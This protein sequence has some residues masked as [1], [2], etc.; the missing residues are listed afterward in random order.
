VSNSNSWSAPRWTHSLARLVRSW[1]QVDRI[2]VSPS[3]GCWLRLKCG[4]LMR[5]DEEWFEVTSRS[6]SAGPDSSW[7]AYECAGRGQVAWLRAQPLASGQPRALYWHSGGE[8]RLLD[9]AEI[10][11]FEREPP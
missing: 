6:V 9:P 4:W 10:E 2:R 7:V 1:W 8:V 3:E 5:V 11:V